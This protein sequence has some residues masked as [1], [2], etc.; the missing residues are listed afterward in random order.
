MK[1]ATLL[2]FFCFALT[3]FN[4]GQSSIKSNWPSIALQQHSNTHYEETIHLHINSAFLLVGETLL[5][6][7]TCLN[8]FTN[9]V[10][11]L[12]SIA[13]IELIDENATPLFRTKIILERGNGAGDFYLPSTLPSGNYTLI[14]YTNWMRNFSPTK[15]FRKQITII[16]PFKKPTNSSLLKKEK[17]T[18]EFF[19]EGGNLLAGVVNIL[20]YRISVAKA[21]SILSPIKILDEKSNVA[22]EFPI[23]HSGVGRF[24]LKPNANSV[25]KALITDSL[26]RIFFETLPEIQN[27]GIGIQVTENLNS[28]NIKLTN[29]SKKSSVKV[30]IEHKNLHLLEVDT[31]F[32]DT[33][34]YFELRKEQLPLGVSQ[35]TISTNGNTIACQRKI[36]NVKMEESINFQIE[37]RKYKTRD[38]V[39]IGLKM[40]D[41]L[42]ASVSISVRGVE[43]NHHQDQSMK[44]Y[45]LENDIIRANS[46]NSI[47]LDDL[48]LF[49]SNKYEIP[50]FKPNE[51]IKYLP[52][53]RGDLLTGKVIKNDSTS[54]GVTNVYLSVPSK[55]YLF[56]I[57]KTDTTGRFFFNTDRI[58]S[59]KNSEVILQVNPE[60]CL[61]CKASFDPEGLNDYSI[62][63]SEELV[64]DSSLRSMIE[65]RSLQ[66][67]IENAYYIQKKDSIVS[68][69]QTSRFY[70][71]PD[72]VYRLADYIRFA[73]M[74]DIFIEYI[75]EVI[76]K[77]G[78]NNFKV[79]VMNIR[80]HEPFAEDPLILIDGIP[81]FDNQQLMTYNPL[82][83]DRIEIIGRRYFYGPLEFHGIISVITNDGNRKNISIPKKEKIIPLQVAKIYYSPNYGIHSKKLE[84]IPDYRIQLF[85]N[86]NIVLTKTEQS[87]EFYTSDIE[88]DFEIILE[89]VT[90]KGIPIYHSTLFQVSK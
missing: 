31:S 86:P 59:T 22:L 6:K 77:K 81:L 5:F 47:L 45:F 61:N 23:N 7:A 49:Q 33:P 44:S 29:T 41:S 58:Y 42:S 50:N 73:T 2:F 19:P 89:G 25:Y 18:I 14:A 74:E 57:S 55:E 27:E 43:K 4:F 26:G 72:K 24:E 71:K 10:S 67:Q 83:I 62:F 30:S 52:E 37:Q 56:F 15:F 34:L 9:S 32:L 11:E 69:Q 39:I 48:M 51:I 84:R 13:H 35:I 65:R 68:K 63:K 64:M 12:S 53:V 21:K 90:K 75:A 46:I 66:S 76:L 80:K 17:S 60:T 40:K 28:F 38:K 3:R 70:G 54:V 87:V 16:N 88:G 82:W 20:G 85:W 36:Y 79:K 1:I 8:Y 78:K